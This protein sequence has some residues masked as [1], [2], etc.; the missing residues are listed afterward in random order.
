MEDRQTMPEGGKAS[1]SAVSRRS[2]W[3]RGVDSGTA[4]TSGQQVLQHVH[5]PPC[6]RRAGLEL[7]LP[8]CHICF[9]SARPRVDAVYWRPLSACGGASVDESE[10]QGECRWVLQLFSNRVCDFER[11]VRVIPERQGNS[12]GPPNLSDMFSSA[13]TV[14]RMS[15]RPSS[16]YDSFGGVEFEE[17]RETERTSR[18]A[19]GAWPSNESC[20][21]ASAGAERR[22]R[23]G[24]PVVLV[25]CTYRGRSRGCRACAG[26]RSS[27]SSRWR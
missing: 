5:R 27:R 7:G 13:P 24:L 8:F 20:R 22:Q 14:A 4:R 26:S 17:L 6:D 10:E 12:G 23:R 1:L 15:F 2:D 21:F 19:A 9:W 11:S 25:A 16:E 18:I 3:I